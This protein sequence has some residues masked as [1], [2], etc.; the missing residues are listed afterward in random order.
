LYLEHQKNPSATVAGFV[1]KSEPYFTIAV[2][3]TAEM[4]ILK[5]YPWLCHEALPEGKPPSWE[6]TFAGWGLPVQVKPGT[7]SVTQPA[8]T[9]CKSSPVPHFYP[10][11]GC[12]TGSDGKAVLT[13]EGML[14]AL[15]V[16]GAF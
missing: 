4:E 10:T 8:L 11:R 13:S 1:L 15:L 16:S 7:M 2:P 5:N 6:I 3:G 12:V 9:W 14:F